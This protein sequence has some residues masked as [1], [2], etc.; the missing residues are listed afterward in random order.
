MDIS[1][2]V[3]RVM[4][5]NKTYLTVFVLGVHSIVSGAAL[6]GRVIDNLPGPYPV[7]NAAV[8]LLAKGVKTTTDTLGLFSIVVSATINDSKEYPH[9]AMRI[10]GSRLFFTSQE[11]EILRIDLFSLRGQKLGCLLD[12]SFGAGEYSLEIPLAA[13]NLEEGDGP[14]VVKARKGK[15]QFVGLFAPHAGNGRKERP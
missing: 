6:T 11:N 13:I 5:K 9:S 7:A 1:L 10:V 4:N 8:S 12:R 15:D 3:E 14:F 2:I